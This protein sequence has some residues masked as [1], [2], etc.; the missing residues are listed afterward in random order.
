M[1]LTNE[2]LE[3]IELLN[4]FSLK[5]TQ[6]GLK[7]HKEAGTAHVSAAARLFKKGMI[8]QDDGGYLTDRGI[9]TTEHVKLL[10]KLLQADA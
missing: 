3:E 4:L 7:V 10:I 6:G 2:L 1:S 5:S 9:E 8:T